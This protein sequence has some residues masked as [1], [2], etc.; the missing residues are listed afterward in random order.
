MGW[1]TMSKGTKIGIIAG[2]IVGA[3]L[4]ITIPTTIA[5]LNNKMP[6]NL[7]IWVPWKEEGSYQTSSLQY[8]VD[9]YNEQNGD[10]MDVELKFVDGYGQAGEAY[11]KDIDAGK[12]GYKKMADMYIDY[13][14]VTSILSA[15]DNEKNFALDLT[16]YGFEASLIAE[17]LSDAS[18]NIEGID[19]D[20]ILNVPLSMS[21]EL[22]TINAPLL[23]SMLHDWSV[24]G[25]TLEISGSIMNQVA[26]AAGGYQ[27]GLIQ[28][29]EYKD[30]GS[31]TVADDALS[32]DGIYV[33]EGTPST[34][35]GTFNWTTEDAIDTVYE[36]ISQGDKDAINK[37]WSV[38]EGFDVTGTTLTIT[39]DTFTDYGK[40]FEMASQLMPLYWN[41]T[42]GN[43]LFTHSIL[44][45][46]STPNAVSTLMSMIGEGES[47]LDENGNFTF[48][49]FE[50]EEENYKAVYTLINDA[51]K[52]GYVRVTGSDD[53]DSGYTSDKLVAHQTA[54]SIGSTA[55]AA[56]NFTNDTTVDGS[57][58]ESGLGRGE[59]VMLSAPSTVT[60]DTLTTTTPTF[61][62]QGPNL[63][64][65]NRSENSSGSWEKRYAER[66][67][68]S[69]AFISWLFGADTKITGPDGEETTPAAYMTEESGY[70]TGASA[71]L[72]DEAFT[73]SLSDGAGNPNSALIN[74]GSW[75][76]DTFTQD[77]SGKNS[78]GAA[79]AYDNVSSGVAFQKEAYGI[80]ADGYRNGLASEF[81]NSRTSVTTDA[82][83]KIK[84]ADTWYGEFKKDAIESG[85]ISGSK[86]TTHNV[87]LTNNK[88]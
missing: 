19:G 2:T 79:I 21:S 69:A 16:E 66:E 41:G 47:S 29:E 31:I 77:T 70:I 60:T 61:M 51:I 44:G 7:E 23:I 42:D 35:A 24:A 54:F 75:N 48:N 49:A 40:L 14:S 10:S 62:Q 20:G 86:T 64:A 78:L 84:D 1:K 63:G 3:A 18:S 25:G 57:V 26:D 88:E 46:D 65:I 33:N 8:V 72:E 85:W 39:D 4:L 43:Y 50:G 53:A 73:S 52:D 83:D 5:V 15:Y 82:T 76:G 30:D 28:K 80:N 45:L 22:Q 32:V 81:K 9:E 6:K 71:L 36:T 59:A 13:S 74:S 38:I 27:D 58:D 87:V 11:K 37:N 17:A 12:K 56:Y 55:G 67:E 68:D 34:T